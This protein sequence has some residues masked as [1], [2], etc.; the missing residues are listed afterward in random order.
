VSGESEYS[1]KIKKHLD[2]S[3]QKNGD[4]LGNGSK[5]YDYISVI[6]GDK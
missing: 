4:F 3:K 2:W 6:F 5:G 1:S